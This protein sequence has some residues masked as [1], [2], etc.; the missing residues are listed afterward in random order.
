MEDIRDWL[1]EW[2]PVWQFIFYLLFTGIL[3]FGRLLNQI[4]DRRLHEREAQKEGVN[5]E[6]A[7][8][9]GDSENW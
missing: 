7:E 8:E 4:W 3:G 5:P 2:Q 6:E 1:K 9:N